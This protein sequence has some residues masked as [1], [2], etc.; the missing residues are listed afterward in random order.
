MSGIT[1]SCW[2]ANICAGPAKSGENF[3]GYQQDA[4][5]GRT[6]FGRRRACLEAKA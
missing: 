2:Q 1:P 4:R 6:S 5:I 3:V